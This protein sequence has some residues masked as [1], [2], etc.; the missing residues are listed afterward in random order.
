M[1]GPMVEVRK[2][3]L[4]TGLAAIMPPP[5]FESLV[6]IAERAIGST[7]EAAVRS[8]MVTAARP[9]SGVSY[10][11][12]CL[13]TVI[14]EMFGA[15]LL[16]DAEA[17]SKLA[18]RGVLPRPADCVSIRHSRLSVLG[19]AEAEDVVAKEERSEETVKSVVESLLKD[20]K[21]VVVDAPAISASR[22]PQSIAPHVDGVLLVVVPNLT[23]IF[24]ISVARRKFAAMG[25]RVLGA[26]YNSTLDPT[27][28]TTGYTPCND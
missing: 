26:I 16:A 21:Y 2:Q 24:D 5:L 7:E 15:S 18:A 14:A 6:M 23:D 17:I 1:N 9:G 20:F 10:I 27:G 8:I 12:S 28:V 13:S 3:E 11:A 19:R 22:V 25:A 4:Q